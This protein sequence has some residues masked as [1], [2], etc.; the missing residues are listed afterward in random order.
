MERIGTLYRVLAEFLS[1]KAA[2]ACR[3]HF[4]LNFKS[5]NRILMAVK[6]LTFCWEICFYFS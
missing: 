6:I 5:L 3:N 1:I 2:G 4:S